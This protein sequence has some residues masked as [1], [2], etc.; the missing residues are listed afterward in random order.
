MM[1]EEDGTEKKKDKKKKKG[2]EQQQTYEGTK[3]PA[4]R[5]F[6]EWITKQWKRGESLQKIDVVEYFPK[7]SMK[8]VGQVVDYEMF[9]TGHNVNLEE[10]VNLSNRLIGSAQV[11]CDRI[12]KKDMTY[13]VRAL[14]KGRGQA[15]QAVDT[16]PLFLRPKTIY[17]D[18]NEDGGGEEV[19]AQSLALDYLKEGTKNYQFDRQREDNNVGDLISMLLTQ[20][21]EERIR[22][23]QERREQRLWEIEQQKM[24]RSILMDWVQA[25][26]ESSDAAPRIEMA[27]VKA[28]MLRDGF[29]AGKN[30]LTGAIGGIMED[31]QGTTPSNGNG[32]KPEED[33][34]IVTRMTQERMLLDNFFEDCK[35]AKIDVALFGEWNNEGNTK[36]GI[37]T[38]DQFIVLARVL[39]GFATADALDDLM[40]DSGKPLAITMA[41]LAQAQ[42]VEGM[43]EGIAAS[44]VQLVTVRKRKK[45]EAEAAAAANTNPSTEENTDV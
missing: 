34:V 41:Q 45:A 33:K 44:L 38:P 37:F 32:S 9:D 1:S 22:E 19:T 23:L 39:K 26:R 31:K 5:A 3:E 18:K 21:R 10:A 2:E 43:T 12:H 24:I 40:P 36:P 27:K 6:A 4:D 29:R 7:G 30:L 15:D 8:G 28:E 11:N 25:I 17:F 35:N 14:D 42:K 20:Q 16:F 13:Y